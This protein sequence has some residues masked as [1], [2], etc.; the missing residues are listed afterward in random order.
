MET[1]GRWCRWGVETGGRWCRWGWRQW[2]RWV[3]TGV[4]IVGQMGGNKGGRWV[5]I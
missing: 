4:E 1:G 5:E 2:D 3:E